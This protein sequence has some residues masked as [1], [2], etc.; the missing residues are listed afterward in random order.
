VR[1]VFPRQTISLTL[2]LQP[3]ETSVWRA[4]SRVLRSPI[5]SLSCV[6]FPSSCALCGDSLL[7]LGRV[8][9]CDLC[10]KGLPP[11][12]GSLCLCCGEDLGP[13]SFSTPRLASDDPRFAADLLCHL[14]R[15]APPAFL[16]AVAYGVYQGHLRSLVHLLKYDGMRPVARRLGKLL[17]ES[18]EPSEPQPMLVVP[19][20][21]HKAKLRQRGFNHATLLAQSAIAELRRRDRRWALQLAP[22]MLERKRATPSQAGLSAPQRRRNLRGAFSAPRP[23]QLAG[24]HVLV[25]D[26]VYTTGATA[27]ACSRVLIDAGAAS[28][29]VATVARAQREGV[30][31]WDAPIF[32]RQGSDRNEG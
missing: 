8:P 6:L 18:L 13:A 22:G 27:R 31:F 4:V 1:C 29:R 28:V 25:I 7:R 19:V 30:A 16:K 11:Q 2:D 14:C 17:A 15:Q 3:S 21:L 12:S 26:D 32:S 5:D 23:A 10:W 24:R 9:V 20:P